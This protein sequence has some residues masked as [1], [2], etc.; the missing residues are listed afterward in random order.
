MARPRNDLEQ[1]VGFERR[2]RFTPV[3]DQQVWE[4]SNR[5]TSR[6]L[7]ETLTRGRSVS[8]PAAA[9][10]QAAR[11][12]YNRPTTWMPSKPEVARARTR[13]PFHRRAPAEWPAPDP[14]RGPPRPRRRGE[15]LVQRRIEERGAWQ[16]RFR[17]PLRARDVRRLGARRQGR[18][19]RPGP[20]GGRHDERLDL[21]R[22]DELLRNDALAPARARA[23]A[24][25]RPDGLAARCTVA[26]EPRQPA[27]G[28]EERE[29]LV[30]RQPAVRNLEREAPGAYVPRG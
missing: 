20:G 24:G 25:S 14:G 23:V 4:S 10:C 5:D 1:A 13:G 16:D 28:R 17:A 21:A 19:C 8:R 7:D 15:R 18:A 6:V 26:G 2:R 22:S 27:R 12:P 9:R 11:A 30:V 3:G 29:T